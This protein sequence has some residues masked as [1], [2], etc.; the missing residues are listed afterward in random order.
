MRTRV[1]VMQNAHGLDEA[2]GGCL[3]R[4]GTLPTVIHVQCGRVEATYLR[5]PQGSYYAIPRLS[6]DKRVTPR[7]GH[8]ILFAGTVG[9]CR[10][11][12]THRWI[13]KNTGRSSEGVINDIVTSIA[14][15]IDSWD[16]VEDN[17]RNL[18]RLPDWV[19]LHEG[20]PTTK[21][22][23]RSDL[24]GVPL[25]VQKWAEVRG[26]HVD[27]HV[28][29]MLNARVNPT[30]VEVHEGPWTNAADSI[31][32]IRGLSSGVRRLARDAGLTMSERHRPS[33]TKKVAKSLA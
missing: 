12:D 5:Q 18:A 27:V 25:H 9:L 10:P 1:R 31:C 6:A 30:F 22:E 4:H 19:M 23:L 32:R 7:L 8:E 16:G 21:S 24:A 13:G 20:E 26:E 3:N 14:L 11:A 17:P 2:V 29:R 28:R 33:R 15:A